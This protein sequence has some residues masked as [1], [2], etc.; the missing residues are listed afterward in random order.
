MK[1]NNKKKFA[2]ALA[3]L[4]V[5]V[6][7]LSTATYAWFTIGNSVTAKTITMTAS[8]PDKIYIASY[9]GKDT[10]SKYVSEL[11]FDADGG[12]FFIGGTVSGKTES[13]TQNLGENFVLLNASSADGE[14]IY[15]TNNNKYENPD[16]ATKFKTAINDKGTDT[17]DEIYSGSVN[18][19]AFYIDV[20]L[21]FTTTGSKDVNMVLDP[22]GS[23]IK[24]NGT[25]EDISPAARMAILNIDGTAMAAST[26]TMY[27]LVPAIIGGNGFGWIDDTDGDALGEGATDSKTAVGPISDP[28]V[29]IGDADA[30]ANVVEAEDGSYA[31]GSYQLT[32]FGAENEAAASGANYYGTI[33]NVASSGIETNVTK[34]IVRIW[35]EGQDAACIND[36]ANAKFDISLK[37]NVASEK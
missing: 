12:D 13:D 4:L 1:K 31:A 9:T 26:G 14:V 18:G 8:A 5:S 2:A 28:T 27:D 35:I 34:V 21:Y 7:T 19:K 24:V 15:S 10:A 37:F 6:L 23:S 16:A 33:T 30:A 32:V 20:P 22:A 3:M 11:T 17:A 25:D 36:N 29:V